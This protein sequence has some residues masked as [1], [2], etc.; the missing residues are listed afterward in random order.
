[1]SACQMCELGT[2]SMTAGENEQCAENAEK[3]C[4]VMLALGYSVLYPY[5]LNCICREEVKGSVNEMAVFVSMCNCWSFVVRPFVHLGLRLSC[6]DWPR[7][8]LCVRTRVVTSG[9]D[10]PKKPETSEGAVLHTTT[11]WRPGAV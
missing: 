11:R 3:T 10:I 4:A 5:F 1:M 2:V 6:H 8:I 9:C 7:M